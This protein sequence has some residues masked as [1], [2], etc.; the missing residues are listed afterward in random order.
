MKS[1]LL[2][3]FTLLITASPALTPRAVQHV[4][5]VQ[6]L[7]GVILI[8]DMETIEI[9]P[10]KDK[11]KSV[12]LRLT[13]ETYIADAVS[14]KPAALIDR[15]NDNVAAYYENGESE[16][17]ALIINIPEDYL[18]PIYARVTRVSQ[19]SGQLSVVTDTGVIVTI[20]ENTPLEPFSTK[21]AVTI[22]NVTDDT[23]ML[24]WNQALTASI[25]ARTTAKKAVLL[26]KGKSESSV[27][28]ADRKLDK[29]ASGHFPKITGIS[30]AD[31]QK[32]VDT[33]L[34]GIFDEALNSRGKT[35][36]KL[37]FSYD[38]KRYKD[39]FSVIIHSGLFPGNTS[40]DNVRTVVFDNEKIL[41]LT[42]ALGEDAYEKA[43]A[44]VRK[45]IEKAGEGQF[46]KQEKDY[47][48][49]TDKT[50]FYIDTDGKPAVIFDKYSIAPGSSGTPQFKIE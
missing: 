31:L 49:V 22:E 17:V 25:P 10:V 38:V 3:L 32:L 4:G 15:K 36:D 12:I 16:A 40:S 9:V 8:D 44:V 33:T 23:D 45:T 6:S 48:Y 27:K 26:G 24:L 46:F 35:D 50:A 37:T 5:A 28:I 39:I 19:K 11:C 2:S 7:S 1:F 21:N 43:D 13:P 29:S 42:D 20:N 18:P 41:K 14:G 34:N 47:R 30:N